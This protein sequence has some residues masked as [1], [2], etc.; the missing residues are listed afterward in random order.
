M[1]RI[2]I[3]ATQAEELRVAIVD[4]QRLHDLDIE[5]GSREQRKSNVY[6]GRITRVEPSLEAAFVEYGGNRH[7]FLPLKEVARQYFN[8]VPDGGKTEIKQALSEGQEVIVQ[9]EKEERGNKGAALTTFVSLAG[10]YL[11]LMPNNPRAG[12]VSRRIEGD[13]RSELRDAMSDLVIPPGMGAIARTAGVGRSTEELQWDM[14]Y[15][16]QLWEAITK[17]GEEKK[18][19]FLIYQESNVIIR[20]LRDYLRDDIGEVVIDEAGIHQTAKDFM[21]QVMPQNLSKLKFYDDEIPLFAR[22]QVES[23]IETAFHRE[24]TL[25]S[26]GAI[27]IDH[28]EAL[29]SIDIN[30]ARSTRGSGIEETALNT[31][32]EAAEEIARQLRLRDLGGLIVIDFIDMDNTKNQRN[33]ENCL[34]DACKEDRARVQVTGISRFGLLEMS[35]QRLRP[36]LG[37]YSAHT[38]PRCTGRGSIRSIESLALSILRL[39]EEEAMKHKTGR[40]LAQVPV[41]V[42][43]FLLNEKRADIADIE[44]RATTVLTVVPSPELE[45][46]HYE[47]RRIRDD[48]LQESD[49]ASASYNLQGET[50]TSAAD[51]LGEKVA[52][53]VN[54]PQPA[55]GRLQRVAPAEQPAKKEPGLLNKLWMAL[56][57][58]FGGGEEI[59]KK[60]SDSRAKR[61]QAQDNRDKQRPAQRGRGDSSRQS[62]QSNQQSDGRGRG[63]NQR[64]R[65]GGRNDRNQSAQRSNKSDSGNGQKKNDPQTRA[66]N[67]D[68]GKEQ[69]KPQEQKQSSGSDKQNE[70]QSNDQNNVQ[71]NDQNNKQDGNNPRSGNS[72]RGRR[73]GR[74]RRGGQ[75]QRD[76]NRENNNDN[77]QTDEQ[78]QAESNNNSN[79]D[80]NNSGANESKPAAQND[81]GQQQPAAQKVEPQPEKSEAPRPSAPKSD[82]AATDSAKSEKPQRKPARAA[83][84]EEK[85]EEKPTDTAAK[86][87][88]SNTPVDQSP[89]PSKAE[90]A[91]SPAPRSESPEPAAKPA[92]PKP[93]STPA[94]APRSESP[95]PAAKPAA[96]KPVSTPAP[97]PR[98]ESPEPAAKPAA[99]KPAQK[100]SSADD[101]GLKQVETKSVETKK[102]GAPAKQDDPTQ[103]AQ[104][105]AGE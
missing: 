96:P 34:R 71:N 95:E 23:Q 60:R 87:N 68:Q 100:K 24:V 67:K 20:A 78:Q 2:L 28:T 42:A 8:N 37:E 89:A 27:V 49:N 74:R 72:R 56:L 57:S 93:E 81:S 19:P 103:P 90:S 77:H 31:N 13:D 50:E 84:S 6:K 25:P 82:G 45:T 32:M 63:G 101:S 102:S 61:G 38:C 17:A 54:K 88:G 76:N 79:P 47:I 5:V 26:G 7:G 94:P 80:N 70:D 98:S 18:A 53:D 58:L 11:V 97:A 86:G 10:R 12:G 105:P 22:F 62:S 55:V 59:S 64:R 29:T 83:K 85:R 75:G 104:T 73:G 33:V 1:K 4:G 40:V 44:K 43:S 3:N 21:Q 30:S 65:S 99:P 48:E 9:V 16:L 46:P 39:L 35:R 41:T 52:H 51:Q 92:A 91:P 14:D 36:S 66:A 15:L 69:S